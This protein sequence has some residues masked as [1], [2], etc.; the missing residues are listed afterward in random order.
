[1]CFTLYIL[2]KGESALH[3]AARNNNVEGAKLLLL[4]GGNVN[5]TTLDVSISVC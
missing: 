3:I 4:N 5:A 2:F 1:M